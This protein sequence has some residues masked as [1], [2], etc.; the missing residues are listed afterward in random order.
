MEIYYNP[1]SNIYKR[2]F[3]AVEE[4]KVV[5]FTIR[6]SGLD[7]HRVSLAI[8]KDGHENQQIDMHLIGNDL[9]QC[10]YQ[11]EKSAGL[12]YYSFEIIY[13]ENGQARSVYYGS[14][15]L[16]GVGQI[17]D[18]AEAV[19]DY[20]L[21]CFNQKDAAPK[22][23]RESVFYQIFPDRFYNGNENG[24]INQPKPN[25]FI[26]GQTHDEP[27]YIKNSD[28]EVVRWDF[29][30]GNL[31]GIMKKIP[32]LKK[33]GVNALYLNP[34]FEARSNHRYDTADYFKI[35][36][37]LGTDE[38]FS[39]LVNE[40]HKN[41]MHLILDG[42]F[43][44][45]G[46][47]SQYFNYDGAYGKHNG[48]AR[49]P[50]SLYFSWFEFDHY[51]DRYRSWWGIKDLPQINKED[52]SFQDFIFKADESVVAHWL[53]KGIDGWRLDVADELPDEFIQGIRH[54][55]NHFKDKVLI[56]EVWEDASNKVSYNTR[57]KYILGDHLHSVMN[58]PFRDAVLDLLNHQKT[59]K[60]IAHR[61][62][63]L[64]EN[65]PRDIFYNLFNN[66]GTHDTERIAT[67][68]HEDVKKLEQAVAMMMYVP[69]VP[70]VYYGDEAGLTGGKDP[71]NRKFYPWESV[72]EA[73]YQIYHRWI[74]H[75][76]AQKVLIDGEFALFYD[77]N[78]FG[79]VRFNQNEMSIL[80]LNLSSVNQTVKL[81]Q[82]TTLNL[83]E[84]QFNI[85]AKLVGDVVLL[86][87]TTEFITK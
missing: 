70:C 53:D 76:N 54:Q 44:H 59:P 41:D 7:V 48:A 85:F 43:S 61:F 18:C 24:V 56:G 10:Q 66:L 8:H 20:Q 49:N 58:Y 19:W 6:V 87:H 83:P 33:L 36:S 73:S 46:R 82:L 78:I 34:I 42:V 9:Y 27:M 64:Y 32:Y 23:Y 72:N 22:W 81:E 31:K 21:T 68:L 45:V 1:W 26:Y 16:G 65:Y 60:Q 13:Q 55:L 77:E 3:G 12:Y 4:G 2:P 50:H 69:G 80:L 40:L 17:Y 35:D 29:Y 5:S 57:R 52:E 62:M 51:P 84:E 37:V 15:E 79:I 67:M 38:D 47:H 11:L 14:N 25:S 63:Q 39:A 74:S 86:P 30:G 75:R 28:G 71:Q